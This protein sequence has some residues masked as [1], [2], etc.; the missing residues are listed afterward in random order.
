MPSGIALLLEKLAEIERM[1]HK[2]QAGDPERICAAAL[3][4]VV[5]APSG[6]ISE[7][8]GS[9]ATA[10]RLWAEHPTRADRYKR[11]L[12]GAVKTLRKAL[13]GVSAE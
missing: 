2:T 7:A 1:L 12:A 10:A 6:A 3:V 13:Q 8:A 9:V 11:P 4:I 5:N